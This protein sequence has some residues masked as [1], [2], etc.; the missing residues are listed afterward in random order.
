M[1]NNIAFFA[2]H[3]DDVQRARRFYERVFDWRFEAWGPPDFYLI[4]TG[5]GED[6]Q[7]QGALQG[8]LEP[9]EGRGMRGYECSIAVDSVDET[10]HR[11]EE[12]GG[13]ITL[14]KSVIP[15]VGWLV[16]FRDPEGNEAAA[17][18]YDREAE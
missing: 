16:K 9:L 14:E 8:R 18:R 12:H 4:T 7:V 15:G 6:S 1:A 5:S 2:I 11:I 17:V 3:A 13:T 10:A